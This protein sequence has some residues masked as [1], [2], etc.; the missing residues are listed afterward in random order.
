[1]YV[2]FGK[3]Y[4]VS[5][6]RLPGRNILSVVYEIKGG[7]VLQWTQDGLPRTPLNWISFLSSW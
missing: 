6:K 4:I 5:F 1:M 2:S 3:T 7:K